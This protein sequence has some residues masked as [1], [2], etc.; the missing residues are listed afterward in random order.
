MVTFKGRDIQKIAVVG[1]GQIGPDIALH[2]AKVFALHGVKIVVLDVAE[3]ALKGGQVKVFKKIDRGMETGAFKPEAADAMKQSLQF[4][5]SDGDVVGASLVVE[6]ATENEDVK[7]KIFDRMEELVS[8]NTI[9]TSNSSHMEP[10]VIFKKLKKPD[11][12]LVT[13]Y[14]FPAE[15]NPIVEVVPGRK[16]DPEVTAWMMDL[17]EYIGKVPIEVKSR[18]GYAIDPIFEGLFQAAAL[19]VEAGLGSTKE[20]D[21]VARG[22]LKLG[23]GPFTAMNLTGGNPITVHGL[24]QMHDKVM[25]WFKSP[26]MLHEAVEK[27]IPWEVPARSETLD[28]DDKRR[29]AIAKRMT[30]AYFGLACEILDSGITNVADLDM[31]AELALVVAA[32]FRMMNKTGTRKSLELV[33]S[34]AQAQPGF[35]VGRPLKEQAERNEPWDIPVVLRKDV[36]DVTVLTI[37][38]PKVLNALNNEAFAQ[39][40]QHLDDIRVNGKIKGVV[41]TGFGRKAFI[42]G[43]D[44]GFL[45]KIDSPEAGER[46]SLESQKA[47]NAIEDFPKPVVAAINGLAFGGGCELA[48]GC[49][50]RI[51]REGLKVLAG[52]PEP[53]LGIIPGAGGTQR[54]PRLVGVEK[55]AGLLRTG[56]PVSSDEAKSIGLVDE[57]AGDDLL[58]RAITRA[59]ELAAS[60]DFRRIKTDPM[61]TPATLPVADIGHLSTAVDKLMVRAILE[62]AKLD[63]RKGLELEAK[64]FGEVVKT[65][66]MKIGIT[67]FMKNGPRSKADFVNR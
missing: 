11:R 22:T 55:A 47:V 40:R 14:F 50:A 36:G 35:K 7:R 13:H 49:H 41:I 53:N 64:L 62:G 23:V 33:E 65:E 43:A 45:A 54:L 24:D 60:G 39:F 28:I 44:V 2:F 30:G 1:S 59:R 56:R 25:P 63:L 31:A 38:R 9:L 61:E 32:P 48:M 6:A 52:Q 20:V 12:S 18:Y 51:A 17:Y 46:A 5:M 10:E 27:K 29:D 57:L 16:T 42:S 66:D 34:Y 37:R 67:N 8:R 19:C 21:Q 58:D 4:T 3:E 26:K 15:R